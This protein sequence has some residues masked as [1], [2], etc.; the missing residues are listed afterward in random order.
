MTLRSRQGSN[1]SRSLSDSDRRNLYMNIGFGA[2]VAAALL[3]LAIAGGLSYWDGH[4]SAAVKVNNQE[5][6]KDALVK[7]AKINAFLLDV[8]KKRTRTL[9]AENHLWSTD[10]NARITAIEDQAA[11]LDT[12][13]ASQL[14]DGTIQLD[15]AAKQG[16]AVTEADVDAQL[17]KLAETPELRHV[18][19]IA[20]VP[21]LQSGQSAPTAAQK[22]EAKAKA[23]QAL[24]ALKGGGDWTKIAAAFSTDATKD[25]GGDIGFI[26][27]NSALDEVFTAAMMKAVPNQF[28]D[29]IEGVD[30]G[31]RIGRVTEILP[32][33]A[34]QSI[35][36]QAKAEGIDA[37]DLRAAVRLA[38]ANEKLS[39]SITDAALAPGPQ[40]K[41]AEIYMQYGASESGP[42]AIRVRHVLYSP[43]HDPAKAS[44]VADTDPAWAAA[45]A[46]AD[47][48]Y[49]KLQ[50][51]PTQFDAIARAE[52]DEAAARTSGGK[53]P[54]F[55][56]NDTGLD[57]S[58]GDAIFKTGFTPGQLL[59][60]VK[61]AF[62]WHVIQVMHYPTDLDWAAKLI[63]QA[64]SAD[65]FAKLARDNS[66]LAS[67]ADGG[68]TGWV[69]KGQLSEA[70]KEAVFAA[71]IGKVS[72]PTTIPSDGLYIFWVSAEETRAPDELQAAK[73]KA[74]AFNSWYSQNKTG[75]TTWEDPAL[76]A[77][78]AGG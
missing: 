39:K 65:A 26:D 23:Q 54:Y 4:L 20:V 66:E 67:A 1:R 53:L 46:L 13:A 33:A 59:A 58:F 10:A 6:S 30:G 68:D 35:V 29:L 9:L 38:T 69:S 75:Y 56:T 21:T 42:S 45:K 49:A 40:R 25:Q 2:I 12:L 76:T 55:S 77:A 19:L 7:Q 63:P 62:G 60:P 43:N 71:P 51:D 73:I 52:S 22:A 57:T 44:T 64:T 72:Q 50:K 16:I 28:S 34:G 37:N 27:E 70:L 47:A 61:S 3:L 18:W 36:E 5:F 24:T 78:A 48:T 11:K 17:A 32:A 41:V 31:Y 14:M 8:Q 74:T 15:L